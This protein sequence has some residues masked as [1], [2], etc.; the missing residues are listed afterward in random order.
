[1]LQD[2]P[3]HEGDRPA[4]AAR[5]PRCRTSPPRHLSPTGSERVETHESTV[6]SAV[7]EDVFRDFLRS[8]LSLVHQ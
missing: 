4:S 5:G 2:V 8:F 7:P 3:D 6:V 1:M